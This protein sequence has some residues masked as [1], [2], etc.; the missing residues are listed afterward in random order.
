MIQKAAQLFWMGGQTCRAHRF[1]GFLC[2]GSLGFIDAWFFRQICLAKSVCDNRT[3]GLN[4][5]I[6]HLH[7]ICAHIGDKAS[8]FRA[9]I[10]TL[11]QLLG[12]LHGAAGRE[13]ELARGFLLQGRGGERGSRIAAGAFGFNC[14]NLPAG[15]LDAGGNGVCLLLASNRELFHLL[16]IQTG[17]PGQ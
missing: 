10:D 13:A 9:D 17:Q 2:I 11:I 15:R 6:A 8:G 14:A 3:G 16:A 7:T 1:M 12:N 4:R 5:L